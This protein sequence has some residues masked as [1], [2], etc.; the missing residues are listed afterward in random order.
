VDAPV[1]ARPAPSGEI[2]AALLAAEYS[3]VGDAITALQ[4]AKGDDA[5]QDLWERYRRVHLGQAMSDPPAKRAQTSAFLAQ[6]EHDALA[7][8]K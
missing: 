2:T 1:P 7:A 8:R 4:R 5:V 6:I 3:R